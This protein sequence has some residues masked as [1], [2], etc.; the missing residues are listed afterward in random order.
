MRKHDRT[1]LRCKAVDPRSLHRIVLTLRR[2]LL[3]FARVAALSDLDRGQRSARMDTVV[4]TSQ[5]VFPCHSQRREYVDRVRC[6]QQRQVPAVHDRI[7]SNWRTDRT[8]AETHRAPPREKILFYSLAAQCA[9]GAK[10]N[11][12]AE[13]GSASPLV[14][15]IKE[16]HQS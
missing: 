6:S 3:F 16:A 11:S 4:S 14:T 15:L 7:P 2:A 1:S 10:N 5:R 13:A 12:R 9:K 8:R